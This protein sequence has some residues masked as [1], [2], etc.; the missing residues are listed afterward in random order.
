M[1]SIRDADA[2]GQKIVFTL[3]KNNVQLPKDL[4][5]TPTD[6]GMANIFA[7]YNP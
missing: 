6:T 7:C 5:G 3:K 1:A 2:L 4:F